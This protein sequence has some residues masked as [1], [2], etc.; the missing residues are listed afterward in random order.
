MLDALDHAILNIV[1]RDNQ[2][3][4]AALGARIGL[5]P[6][7]CRRRLATLRKAGV[8]IADVSIVDP[9]K[10]GLNITLH[11]LVT[12]D[13]DAA[14]AHRAFRAIVTAAPE[15]SSCSYVTGPA[16]YLATICIASMADYEEMADRLFGSP[17]VKRVETMVEMRSIKRMS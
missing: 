11:A 12:L 13:R 8:I 2:I 15:I 4:H 14:D 6:S 17:P 16:D 5:S 10:I 9:R 3:T 7:S 1:Q